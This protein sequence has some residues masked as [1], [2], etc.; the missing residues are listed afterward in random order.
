MPSLGPME[1]MAILVVA[2]L[3]LGPKKLPEAGR[4]V[5]KALAEFRRWSHE[6]Q[7]DVRSAMSDPEPDSGA[8]VNGAA[9]NGHSAA[10]HPQA[11]GRP[12]GS[13]PRPPSQFPDGQ[14]FD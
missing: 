8:N 13:D 1:V 3:V 14:S 11:A 7:G 10:G 6:V 4:Q 2:L 5:G 9:T 12:P